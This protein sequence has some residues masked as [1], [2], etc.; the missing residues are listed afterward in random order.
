MYTAPIAPKSSNCS[1]TVSPKSNNSDHSDAK[2]T[3]MRNLLPSAK[4]SD[5][6]EPTKPSPP[7]TEEEIPEKEIMDV[8][9]FRQRAEALEGLP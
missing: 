4:K 3:E 1:E 9:S 7:M 8:K 2:E 5:S 6:S